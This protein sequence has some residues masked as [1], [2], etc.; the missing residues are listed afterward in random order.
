[1]VKLVRRQAHWYG[2][3]AMSAETIRAA[4]QSLTTGDAEPLVSLMHAE[5]KWRGRRSGWRLWQPP[6]S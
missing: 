4:Y 2:E 5:M 6:P 3:G 1:M